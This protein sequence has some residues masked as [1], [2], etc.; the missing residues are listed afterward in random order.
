MTNDIK[1]LIS[2]FHALLEDL[3]NSNDQLKV[4]LQNELFWEYFNKVL[5]APP[6]IKELFTQY[7][8]KYSVELD[9]NIDNLRH[10][11]ISQLVSDYVNGSSYPTTNILLESNN[12]IFLNE[13][14]FQNDLNTAFSIIENKNLKKKIKLFDLEN[15]FKIDDNEIESAFKVLQEK[16]EHAL[17]KS[18]IKQWSKE[19]ID[20]PVYSQNRHILTLAKTDSANIKS[21]G[22]ALHNKFKLLVGFASAAC[23]IGIIITIGILYHNNIESNLAYSSLPAEEESLA[24]ADAAMTADTAMPAPDIALDNSK[25]YQHFPEVIT[26]EREINLIQESGIGFGPKSTNEYKIKFHD[27]SFRL[28]W[29]KDYINANK[30]KSEVIRAEIDSL[31]SLSRKYIFNRNVIEIFTINPKTNIKLLVYLDVFYLHDGQYFYIVKNTIIPDNLIKVRN[32]ETNKYLDKIIF[33]N[34]ANQD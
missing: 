6:E 13:I 5:F 21:E 23:L 17:L 12:K 10:Q 1:I 20:E 29:L 28:A 31:Q 2:I 30:N 9:K 32:V 33:E 26:T 15:E 4:A 18:K 14:N 11:Y 8:I 19:K 7:N 16:E 34:E 24:A 25:S 3:S 27:L 22:K